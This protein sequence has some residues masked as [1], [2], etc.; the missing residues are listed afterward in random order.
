VNRANAEPFLGIV[1]ISVPDQEEPD[2]KIPFVRIA[3]GQSINAIEFDP[4]VLEISGGKRLKLF[5]ENVNASQTQFA[6]PALTK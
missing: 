1:R 5:I 4:E 6:A 2:W 3:H